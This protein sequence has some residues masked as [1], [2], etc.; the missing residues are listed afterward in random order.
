MQS[1]T[2]PLTLS[3]ATKTDKGCPKLTVNAVVELLLAEDDVAVL[4]GTGVELALPDDLAL[5]GPRLLVVALDEDV[6]TQRNAGRDGDAHLLHVVRH[7]AGDRRDNGAL[8][9]YVLLITS[10]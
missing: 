1:P 6:A 9:V 10:A 2:H 7:I 5:P 4:D 8:L 3:Q